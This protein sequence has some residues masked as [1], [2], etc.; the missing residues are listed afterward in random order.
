MKTRN[1]LPAAKLAQIKE[2]APAV[3]AREKTKEKML[4]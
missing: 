2:F 1:L 4:A 3:W